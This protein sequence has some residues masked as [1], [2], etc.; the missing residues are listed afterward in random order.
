[1]L[2]QP[3]GDSAQLT[4][5]SIDQELSAL[6]P[7]QWSEQA[8]ITVEG[9]KFAEIFKALPKDTEATITI[10]KQKLVVKCGRSRFTM[11]TLPANDFP[12]FATTDDRA[13][14][15]VN[16]LDLKQA[17]DRAS[18]AMANGDVRSYLNGMHFNFTTE[19]LDVVATDGHRLN[20]TR[21]EATGEPLAV[22]VP[23]DAVKSLM[24]IMSAVNTTMNIGDNSLQASDGVR[25]V[26]VK[27]I[28]GRFPDYNRVVPK[29][30]PHAV[31]FSRQELNDAIVRALTLS[32]EKFRAVKLNMANNE[33]VITA[34]NSSDEQ[35]EERIPC[36]YV[37]DSYEIAFNGTYVLQALSQI[38]TSEIVVEFG[39]SP[40][41]PA[42]V[43]DG[44]FKAVI[45]PIRS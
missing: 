17:C 19:G 30:N 6:A 24:G 8:A 45:M 15:S 27:L 39:A 16:G 4:A 20:I 37:G 11:N 35:A 36:T 21:V 9:K 34:S 12:S 29:G 3:S 10:A 44:E 18:S 40:E 31:E 2:I 42:L 32:N 22:T 33:C 25:T 13:S 23:R 5:T 43:R 28:D 1:L 41:K 38:D 26:T 7:C 14:Y